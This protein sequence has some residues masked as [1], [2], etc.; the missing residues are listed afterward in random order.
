M[1][2]TCRVV[3]RIHSMGSWVDSSHIGYMISGE[4]NQFKVGYTKVGWE[5]LSLIGY[6]I[7][8]R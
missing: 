1:L 3:G 5:D 2:D 7:S 4:K 6:L 8:V